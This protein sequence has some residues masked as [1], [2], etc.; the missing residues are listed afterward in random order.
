MMALVRSFLF[1]PGCPSKAQ[2]PSGALPGRGLG[3]SLLLVLQITLSACSVGHLLSGCQAIAPSEL[4]SGA[5]P[6][7][8]V[9]GVSGGT[10][11]FTWG[12]GRDLVDLAVGMTYAGA[13]DPILARVT[14]RGHPAKVFHLGPAGQDGIGLAWSESDC[15][16][17]V[18]L[19]P[20]I[21]ADELADYAGRY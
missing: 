14:V 15:D 20:E 1:R 16:Y 21:T 10:K 6:G 5:S 3:L 11:H 18:F 2:L 12:S 9:E 19:A 13:G 7:P 17:N 8:A 4:P